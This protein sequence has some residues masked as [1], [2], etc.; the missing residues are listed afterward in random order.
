V[1]ELRRVALS[2]RLEEGE[3]EAELELMVGALVR[4]GR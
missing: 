4:M 2:A 3:V 1:I